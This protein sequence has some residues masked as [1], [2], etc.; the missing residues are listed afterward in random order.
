MLIDN[1]YTIIYHYMMYGWFCLKTMTSPLYVRYG[2]NARWIGF[3]ESSQLA[4]LQLFSS[5][6]WESQDPEMEVLYYI[7]A[8][9]LGIF[10]Y[11]GLNNRPYIRNRYLQFRILEIS[12]WIIGIPPE[13]IYIGR[14]VH[15]MMM[16]DDHPTVSRCDH[17]TFTY[18][19]PCMLMLMEQWSSIFDHPGN[20]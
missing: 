16:Y 17:G 20:P 2:W 12:H 15:G 5:V 6:Q 14:P 8:Y 4:V 10:P 1:I 11:I 7:R 13:V 9:F 3:V 18:I 19:I